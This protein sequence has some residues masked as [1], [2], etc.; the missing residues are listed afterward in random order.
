MPTSNRTSALRFLPVPLHGVI[1]YTLSAGCL[2]LPLVIACGPRTKAVLRTSGS[3][4]IAY[5]A[6]THYPAG[7]AKQGPLPTLSLGTHLKNE[8]FTGTALIVSAV[9]VLRGEPA[10]GRVA[11][12][13]KGMIDVVGS[14]ITKR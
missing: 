6:L 7:V 1:D 11:V 8:T 9:T 3:W 4:G 12:G 2:A 5:S 13:V 10:I 14:L